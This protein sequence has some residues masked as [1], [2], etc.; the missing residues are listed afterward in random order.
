MDIGSFLDLYACNPATLMDIGNS[1]TVT[2][3]NGTHMAGRSDAH[4]QVL[5]VDGGHENLTT[6]PEG[7]ENSF[8]IEGLEWRNG[9]LSTIDSSTFRPWPN[10]F[11]INLGGNKIVSLDGDLFKHTR[12][13]LWIYF[14]ANLLEHVGEGLLTGLT[15][16]MEVEFNTNPCTSGYANNPEDIQELNYQLPIDCPPLAITTDPPTT[17]ISTFS[18]TNNEDSQEIKKMIGELQ[19]Q[20][21]D[22]M[23]KMM[24]LMM[25]KLEK[26]VREVNSN[27][28]SCQEKSETE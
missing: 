23:K 10:L 22:E 6:I 11:Y 13:L 5:I 3:I 1:T 2:E 18:C 25:E 7:I 17:T 28:C 20:M 15:D 27:N 24:D 26:A 14:D 4:V 21:K 19:K 8:D 9:N 12:K 16:L